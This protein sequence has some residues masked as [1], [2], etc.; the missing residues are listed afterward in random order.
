M[1]GDELFWMREESVSCS[2]LIKAADD[3]SDVFASHTTWTSY[4]NMLRVYKFFDFQGPKPYKVSFSSKPGVL[5]S[6]DDFYVLPNQQLIVME[7]TNGVMDEKLYD[8]IIPETLLT[9]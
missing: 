9:W 6:K 7:T 3:W 5:Y 2:V 8:K 1:Q 4:Q